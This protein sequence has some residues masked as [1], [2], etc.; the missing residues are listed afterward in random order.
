MSDIVLPL[1]ILRSG[2]NE[3]NEKQPRYKYRIIQKSGIH[4]GVKYSIVY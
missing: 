2:W 4:T 3:K 1:G